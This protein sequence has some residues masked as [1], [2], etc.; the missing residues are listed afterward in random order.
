MIDPEYRL[1]HHQRFS[2]FDKRKLSVK[3]RVPGAFLEEGPSFLDDAANDQLPQ[4]AWIDPHFKDAHMLG[5]N[6]NDDHPPEDV[7]AGQD[8]V[9]SIFHALRRSKAW[10]KTLF[11]ITYDEHGGFFDHVPPPPSPDDDPAFGRY[12]VRVPAIVVSPMVPPRSTARDGAGERILFDHTS[13][14][15]TI[16]LRHCLDEQGRI[17]DMGRRVSQANHLGQVLA[18]PRTEI[19]DHTHLGKQMAGWRAEWAAARFGD[20]QTKSR[21]PQQLTELQDGIVRAS[22]RLREAGL[23]EGHP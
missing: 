20:P 21:R 1:G 18:G 9:L 17:P 8:L 2:F 10:S 6:S 16:L 13:I 4:V 23:P 19:A 5:P 11:L 14:I 12:G 22:R 3:E 15:K 7:T